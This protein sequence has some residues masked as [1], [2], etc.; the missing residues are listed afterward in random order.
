M[1]LL[2]ERTQVLG[3][4]GCLRQLRR[5]EHATQRLRQRDARVQ[6][7]GL[8]ACQMLLGRLESSAV[9]SC[10]R[11]LRL[12]PFAQFIGLCSRSKWSKHRTKSPFLAWLAMAGSN[13]AYKIIS[14]CSN[15]VS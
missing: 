7:V 11:T 4:V 13:A 12:I 5:R 9:G 15:A 10:T 6:E 2:C 14:A 8:Q 1:P 3:D